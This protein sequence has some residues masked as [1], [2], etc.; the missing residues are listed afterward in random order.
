MLLAQIDDVR[1]R[2]KEGE[3]LDHLFENKCDEL[4]ACGKKAHPA[5][6]E[7]GQPYTYL[8]IDEAAN[9]LARYLK[10]KGIKSGD[11]VALLLERSRRTYIAL[12][13]IMKVNAA[14]VPLD[15]AFPQDRIGFILEDSE[16]AA[17]LSQ[18]RYGQR[19][20]GLPQQKCFID[21]DED[22]I[23]EFPGHRLDAE[24]RGE[25]VDEL[26]YIIYTSG[27][28]GK[29]KGVAIEHSS[30][31][32][33]VRVAAETYGIESHDRAF[34]GMTIAF[35]FSV[36]ELW[37]PLMA[38]ATLVPA[39]NT[40]T[41]VGEE[42]AAFLDQEQIS[43]LCCVPTLLATIERDLPHLRVL[44]VSGETCPQNLVLRWAA[45]HRRILNA[46]GPTEA[47][48]TAT[49][50]ELKPDRTV[51]IG[52]PLPTYSVVILAPEEDRL[53]PPGE[54]GEIAIGGICLARGYV[55][56]P[57][58]TQQKFIPDFVGLPS[59]PS[60]RIYRSGDLGRFDS[61]GEI[62]YLGRKD[63]QVKIRGYRIELAEIESVMLKLPGIAQAVVNTYESEPG[64]VELAAYFSPKKGT[65]APSPESILQAL[66]A[67]LPPYMLPAYIEQLPIIPMTSSHKAD[68][69]ALPAP[70]GPRVAVSSSNYVAPRNEREK[71]LEAEIVALLKLPRASIKDD[72]FK[73][74]GAHSLLMAR[75]CTAVRSNPKLESI[76]IR[77]V[78]ANPT[79]ET[80]ARQMGEAEIAAQTR[81]AQSGRRHVPSAFAYYGCGALQFAATAAL[82]LAWW[83]M[84]AEGFR[85]V[86]E[87]SG[88]FAL[89]GR[90]EA[91]LFGIFAVTVAVPVAAKWLLI[92]RWKHE[93]FPIWSLKYFRFWL[94]KAL[95][96]ASPMTLW[97][98]G[99]PAYNAYLRLLGA[100]IGRD[101]CIMSVAPVCTDLFSVGDDT[102]IRDSTIMSGYVAEG[103]LISTGLIRIGSRAFVGS[104][105]VLEIDTSIGDRGQLGHSS[106]LRKHQFIANGEIWHGTPAERTNVNYCRLEGRSCSGL[107]RWLYTFVTSFLS[108]FIA[109]PIAV[110]VAAL[111]VRSLNHYLGAQLAGYPLPIK[112][113]AAAPQIAVVAFVLVIG[114][115]ILR[116]IVAS[117]VSRM[118]NTFLKPNKEYPL[119][120]FHYFVHRLLCATSNSPW[121][122]ILFGDSSYIIGYLKLIGYRLNKVVQTGANFGL[123]Q[124]HES[125][126]HCNIG[127]GSMV[128]DGLYM[129]NAE[130]SSSSFRIG[131]VVIGEGTYLG[132]NIFYPTGG[133][134]GRN[135]LLASKVMI[136]IDGVVRENAGLLGSPCFEIPRCVD[137]DKKV[138]ALSKAKRE[139]GLRRKNDYNR[140]SMDYCI[141]AIS[142]QLFVLLMASYAMVV[143]DPELGNPSL[144]I[145]AGFAYL[146]TVGYWIFLERLSLR[147]GKLEARTV[148]LYH[149]YYFYHERHWKFCAN[150]MTQMFAGTPLKNLTSML[151]GVKIGRRVF[152][153]G[154]SLYD[155]T[156][157]QIGDHA[158]LNHGCVLQ[159]HSLEEGAFKSAP[160]RIGSGCTIFSGA[161]VHYDVDMGDCV[162]L[163]ANAFLMKGE[164][165]S[166]G[167]VWEGN[168]AKRLEDTV[169]YTSARKAQP[170]EKATQPQE[171]GTR[172]SVT[173]E[174][175]AAARPNSGGGIFGSLTKRSDQLTIPADQPKLPSAAKL[176]ASS[177]S[178]PLPTNQEP[179]GMAWNGRKRQT[180]SSYRKQNS[181]MTNGVPGAKKQQLDSASDQPRSQKATKLQRPISRTSP[182]K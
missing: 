32:N 6:I 47:T 104:A 137:R 132:N 68:R 100:K 30:I 164:T 163:G 10:A 48:V 166:A 96:R 24:E 55:N 91:V 103:N 181:S 50:I 61:N 23:S 178:C 54:V 12:L 114:M 45:P 118:L 69:K 108:L 115:L 142:L 71:L 124:V 78:Y 36:E 105:S 56:R 26:A 27:T 57:D 19:L 1:I 93:T 128:S 37:V 168:P 177:L 44:L 151:L 148:N 117:A 160:V 111:I 72:F 176:E 38:G 98:R 152:D 2:W 143:Y 134:T 13:A 159:C 3:R 169:W 90:L 35:D 150:K 5:V 40:A 75:F 95:V 92:G 102:I 147:F 175:V 170:Q 51:T 18:S 120:G 7:R 180:E 22:A 153:D 17:I 58:L 81:P 33:F 20:E 31:C 174:F 28:T 119:F 157:I 155:K 60:K 77:D 156:L 43:V 165:P 41:L 70:K 9:K 39:P 85:W 15:A 62:E 149:P 4:A 125:P 126:F 162:T 112:F 133:K 86:Y 144:L 101:T 14:Y 8:D 173:A 49:I 161:F 25:P 139:K 123:D 141:L 29:P 21:V 82:A 87:F 66:R 171:K 79:I 46:Y 110:L 182:R 42:L 154:A 34:Q 52:K 67:E 84:A 146:F 74:L 65:P 158:N 76:S 63:T 99:T 135:V 136:P 130:V 59:N 73:D 129:S 106:C 121:L 53:M 131:E 94:V 89:F 172:T 88:T 64:L 138:A 11:R 83:A 145:Y 107:R 140:Q 122:S 127:T 16:A 116:L 109:V 97:F 113:L 167:T 80:L 179:R